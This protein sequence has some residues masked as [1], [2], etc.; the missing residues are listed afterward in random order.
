MA[1]DAGAELAAR[2]FHMELDGACILESGKAPSL[3]VWKPTAEYPRRSDVIE[4]EAGLAAGVMLDPRG[5]CV[6]RLG[7][8]W[9]G[10]S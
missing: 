8:F 4:V 1:P 5:S 6:D 3:F 10:K 7:P 9:F 2:P